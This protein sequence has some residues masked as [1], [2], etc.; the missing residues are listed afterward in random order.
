MQLVRGS[1]VGD[2]TKHL[3]RALMVAVCVC[4]MM[5]FAKAQRLPNMAGNW[6][7]AYTCTQG[8]TDLRLAIFQTDASSLTAIFKFSANSTNPGVPSGRYWM[9]GAYQRRSGKIVLRPV[10]WIKRP[11]NYIM[12]GLA[13]NA[14]NS[15]STISGTVTNSK[16]SAFTVSRN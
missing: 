9:S 16:C 8:L 12:V 11:A 1:I 14:A 15:N 3:S 6:S 7:G 5:N 13:G 10:R 4:G 2:M